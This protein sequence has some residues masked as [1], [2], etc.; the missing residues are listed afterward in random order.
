VIESEVGLGVQC[1]SPKHHY[2]YI[3]IGVTDLRGIFLEGKAATLLLL[4]LP[5]MVLLSLKSD[6][7]S[8]LAI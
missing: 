2:F 5:D 6:S 4:R 7:C 3:E 8:L 1:R